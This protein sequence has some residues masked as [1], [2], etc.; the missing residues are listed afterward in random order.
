MREADVD[1]ERSWL[2]QHWRVRVR[3]REGEEERKSESQRRVEMFAGVASRVLPPDFR[4]E[5]DGDLS[6]SRN[7]RLGLEGRLR[8]LFFS[9]L[10]EIRGGCDSRR[11]SARR[12]S[13]LNS[14]ESVSKIFVRVF[15][16]RIEVVS[17][18]SYK[19]E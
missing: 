13:K 7:D 19:E 10:D 5:S 15:L 8:I 4:I 1:P 2:H 12:G 16:E 3:L 9:E 14:R 17:N 6:S 11:T 18:G